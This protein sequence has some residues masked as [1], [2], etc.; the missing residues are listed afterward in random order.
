MIEERS[1][2]CE[3]CG[4]TYK[5]A[6]EANQCEELHKKCDCEKYNSADM[7]YHILG[8]GEDVKVRIYFNSKKIKYHYEDD[9]GWQTKEKTDEIDISFCPF[10]GR[11][12]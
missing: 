7:F 3:I 2:K 5:T 1:Y 10:C 9:G 8:Y 6:E 4:E 12:L 11:K